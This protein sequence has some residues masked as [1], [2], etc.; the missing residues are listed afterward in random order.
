MGLFVGSLTFRVQERLKAVKNEK[1]V[2]RQKGR[3]FESS[4]DH[5]I[6]VMKAHN[7][8]F[9]VKTRSRQHD[10]VVQDGVFVFWLCD[11]SVEATEVAI[12]EASGTSL[13]VAMTHYEEGQVWAPSLCLS[14]EYA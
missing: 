4:R 13:L 7:V 2:N 1:E 14:F 8:P 11:G 3:I 6:E 10:V 12:Q 9:A 5:I